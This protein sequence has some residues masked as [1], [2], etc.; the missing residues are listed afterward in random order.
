MNTTKGAKMK[1]QLLKF[2]KQDLKIAKTEGVVCVTGTKV[3]NVQIKLVHSCLYRFE[4]FN[5]GELLHSAHGANTA[6]EAAEY[7]SSLY[8]VE[9]V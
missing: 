5:T 8:Q 1:A 9:G 4:N 2:A 6:K 7:L 3:G